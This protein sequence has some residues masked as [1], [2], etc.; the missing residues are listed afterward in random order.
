M[1]NPNRSPRQILAAALHRRE[2]SG[3]TGQVSRHGAGVTSI[4]IFSADHARFA[5]KPLNAQGV[6]IVEDFDL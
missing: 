4:Q 3:C 2:Y 5:S 6:R 1:S